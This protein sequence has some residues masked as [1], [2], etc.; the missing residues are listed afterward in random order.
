M[1]PLLPFCLL[2]SLCA[3]TSG[4]SSS[5]QVRFS[6]TYELANVILALTPYGIAD[7]SEVQKNTPYYAE[8]MATFEGMKSHPLLEKVNYSREKWAE[9]LSFR[10]DAYAFGVDA[11]GK[12][13]RQ[14]PFFANEGIQPFDDHL[15]LVEDFYQKS[16]FRDFYQKHL[17]YYERITQQYKDYYMV[18]EMQSFLEAEF[19]VFEA[20]ETNLVVCSPLVNRMNCRRILNESTSADFATLALFLINDKS[21]TTVDQAQRAADIHT[22]FTE[23]DHGYVN[24]ISDK[25]A[26]LIEKNFDYTRWDRESGYTGRDCFNEYMT[27]AVYDLFTLRHFPQFAEQANRNWHFQNNNRGFVASSLFGKKLVEL[28]TDRK[29]GSQIRDLY[30]ALLK[31]TAKVQNKIEMPVLVSDSTAISATKSG[32]PIAIAFSAPLKK[33]PRLDAVLFKVVNGE[34]ERLDAMTFEADKTLIFRGNKLFVTVPLLPKT[35]GL[36]GLTFNI[37]GRSYELVGQSGVSAPCPSRFYIRVF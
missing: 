16:N 5:V 17:P 28:Y 4:Q 6:E 9:Y 14:F 29:P 26:D 33:I 34:R 7:E 37:Y 10:T 11:R 21:K 19:G 24:P 30:P 32:E 20:N 35:P 22:L 31:W 23:M 18:A 27:W 8:V 25:Y 1:K 3:R 12:I 36:Y 15:A 2:L 13:T